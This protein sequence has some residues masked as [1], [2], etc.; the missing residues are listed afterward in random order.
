MATPIFD[1]SRT[2]QTNNNGDEV[3]RHDLNVYFLKRQAE[4]DEYLEDMDKTQNEHDEWAVVLKHWVKI[5][6]TEVGK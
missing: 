5:F 2:L 3:R 6:G 4:L 1:A